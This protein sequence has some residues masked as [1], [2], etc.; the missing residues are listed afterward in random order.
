LV[1]WLKGAKRVC[2]HQYTHQH[3]ILYILAK[4]YFNNT[5]NTREEIEK[6]SK[7]P[8]LGHKKKC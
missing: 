8:F 2:P 6:V 4:D 3:P 7:L 5:V 1:K